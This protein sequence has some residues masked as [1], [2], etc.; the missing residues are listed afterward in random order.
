MPLEHRTCAICDG[1]FTDA[2]LDDIVNRIH[3][4]ASGREV[5]ERCCPVCHPA[6]S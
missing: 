6:T 4:L 1:Q 2:D 5:H 3:W